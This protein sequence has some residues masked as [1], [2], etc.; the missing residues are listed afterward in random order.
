MFVRLVKAPNQISTKDFEAIERY[1]VVLCQRTS[2][3][4]HGNDARKQMFSIG[5]RKIEN[6]PPTKD[7]LEQQVKR[8]VYQAGHIWG[9]SLPCY[10]PVPSPLS[11]GWKQQDDTSPWT[12]CGTTLLEVA[13]GCQELLKCSC[14]SHE[15]TVASV[16]SQIYDALMAVSMGKGYSLRVLIILYIYWYILTIRLFHKD[17]E[18]YDITN[19]IEVFKLLSPISDMV[20]LFFGLNKH[21]PLFNENIVYTCF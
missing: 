14:K 3:L 20:C 9:Q 15:I 11:C 5:S 2:S 1:V 7:A 16:T 19:G 4:R 18:N 13:N 12:P 10:S 17:A 8:A 6:L 21:F